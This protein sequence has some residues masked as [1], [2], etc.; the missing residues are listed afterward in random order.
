VG[1]IDEEILKKGLEITNLT[2]QKVLL[3]PM[4]LKTHSLIRQYLRKV[5]KTLKIK[6]NYF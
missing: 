5:K 3:A 6:F 1:S 2:L 4:S